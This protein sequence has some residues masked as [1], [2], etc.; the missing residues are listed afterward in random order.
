MSP[1]SFFVLLAL[2]AVSTASG[3]K[4]MAATPSAAGFSPERIREIRA[5]AQASIDR[6]EFT[7]MNVAVIQHGQRVV[8]ESVGFQNRETNKPMQTDTIF[9]LASMTKPIISAAVMI[10]YD[11]GKFQ[12]DD[13][14]SKYVP[15]FA[16]TKVLAREDGSQTEVVALESPITIRQLLTHTSGLF[17]NKGY[18]SIPRQTVSLRD[19]APGLAAV[20]LSHQ[21]G[22]AW[23]YGASI[24]LLGYLIEVWSKQSLDVFLEKRVFAPLGMKDTGFGVPAVKWS[25][26]A[27]MYRENERGELEPHPQF[28][29]AFAQPIFL[30]GG[31]GLYSTQADYLRFCQMLLNGGELEGPRILRSA[32]VDSMFQVHVPLEL[33]PAGGPGG[34]KG[35]AFGMG[36]AILVQSAAADLVGAQGEFTWGGAYCTLFWIDRK[37]DLAGVFMIQQPP[38]L[39]P[40]K[41]WRGY[42]EFKTLVYQALEK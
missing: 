32:T 1:K 31:G 6:K 42:K 20:P 38:S 19:W 28:D 10:L 25:R 34:R 37:N 21:P 8:S 9:R 7:G 12:L 35:Y 18:A 36:G 40:G 3:Q 22:K 26:V 30:S 11:E 4:S 5:A 39:A 33:I 27:R 14:V 23:R 16:Q 24:D 2:S 17:N 13:P 41:R 15:A 29:G